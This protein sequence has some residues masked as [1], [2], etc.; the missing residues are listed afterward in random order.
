MLL[1]IV[2]LRKENRVDW[3]SSFKG[4]RTKEKGENGLTFAIYNLLQNFLF[5]PFASLE[6]FRLEY[7]FVVF[8]AGKDLWPIPYANKY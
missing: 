3:I 8:L 6:D 7:D 1:L 4:R 5:L 2:D